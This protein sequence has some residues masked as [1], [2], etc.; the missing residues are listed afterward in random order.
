MKTGPLNVYG[1]GPAP[2]AAVTVPI[3]LE[4]GHDPSEACGSGQ[5]VT[6]GI[7]PTSPAGSVVVTLPRY[8]CPSERARLNVYEVLPKAP[9]LAGWLVALCVQEK[10]SGEGQP[11]TLKTLEGLCEGAKGEV[12]GVSV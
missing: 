11:L 9:A 10:G 8:C 5:S 6:A 3:W 4:A 7:A 12:N 2:A 1:S